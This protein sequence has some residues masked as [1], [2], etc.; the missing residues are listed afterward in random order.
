M[1]KT[2]V[3]DP[4]PAIFFRCLSRAL[5]TSQ[6]RRFWFATSV[7]VQRIYT[8][9]PRSPG[10][11][12]KA[13]LCFLPQWKRPSSIVGVV[14]ALR[15]ISAFR[16]IEAGRRRNARFRLYPP[17][18]KPHN[19]LMHPRS[20]HPPV[21]RVSKDEAF[22]PSVFNTTDYHTDTN[23]HLSIF[24]LFVQVCWSLSGFKKTIMPGVMI[25][26]GRFSA[27]HSKSLK[28]QTTSQQSVSP[29]SGMLNLQSIKQL[30]IQTLYLV[31][32]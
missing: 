25:H 5:M 24:N 6:K 8:V 31:T 29:F 1:I 16:D 20:L 32:L 23:L 26:T 3:T 2:V 30:Q 10:L 14:V 4:R 12:F 11:T 9:A 21:C 28:K 18:W 27:C 15:L 22:N 17:G 19:W 13:V 7:S